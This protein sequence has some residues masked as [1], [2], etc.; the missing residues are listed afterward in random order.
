MLLAFVT[1]MLLASCTGQQPCTWNDWQKKSSCATTNKGSSSGSLKSAG[2]NDDFERTEETDDAATMLAEERSS[3]AK[4]SSGTSFVSREGVRET[5]AALVRQLKEDAH[6]AVLAGQGGNAA[7]VAV[8]TVHLT[9]VHTHGPVSNYYHFVHDALLTFYPLY[10]AF[11]D[12]GGNPTV[13]RVVLWNKQSFGSFAPIFEV[14]AG[15]V[16]T[17]SKN[18][19]LFFTAVEKNNYP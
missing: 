7:D 4:W 13:S 19:Y 1:S 5:C 2:K 18:I 10:K 16:G 12:D 8:R 14:G 15:T 17:N 6:V 9:Y 3:P 11:V